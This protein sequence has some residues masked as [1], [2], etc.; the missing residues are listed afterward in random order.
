MAVRVFS[1][2]L[3]V[4][5]DGLIGEPQNPLH[6]VRL[7]ARLALFLE[8]LTRRLL[9]GHLR[10]AGLLTWFL[11]AGTSFG[12]SLA[13]W[14]LARVSWLS[15]LLV[16]GGM[17]YFC[18][19]PRGLCQE[20]NKV[21]A[22]LR[23]GDLDGARK[24]LSMI[25]GRDTQS[26]SEE[27]ILRAAI[28]TIAENFSDGV[29]A[30]LFFIGLLGPAGGMLYKAVNTMDSLFGYRNEKYR[31]FGFFPAK[32][33]DLFNLI[34]ARLSALLTIGAAIPAGLSPKGALAVWH[35]DRRKHL[36][37]NS[38]HPESA[39]AGALGI[40]MGG[41][42]TYGGIPVE[43]PVIGE[44]VRPVDFSRL[45]ESERLLYAAT[46]LCLPPVLLAAALLP[47]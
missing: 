16:G 13:L 2:L 46:A 37:P 36:S 1:L 7:M 42:H 35:R 21:A 44:E 31:D 25:V 3:G 24:Q 26:L 19:C 20:A 6:P 22:R 12:V 14:R 30:P 28:E 29:A 23:A 34:P 27:E 18:I 41:T 17:I 9:P 38:A 15:L 8:R 5:L 39:F 40:R 11:T 10:A 47:W 33:D 32:L 4:L 43:K 45:R